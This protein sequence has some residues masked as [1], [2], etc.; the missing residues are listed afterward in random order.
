MEV[1]STISNIRER[2]KNIFVC[3]QDGSC[4]KKEYQ[5]FTD[6]VDQVIVLIQSEEN[7]NLEDIAAIL[8]CSLISV[9]YLVEL[10]QIFAFLERENEKYIV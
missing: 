3:I 1:K 8:Q 5:E 9:K 6:L 2:F 4:S 10:K 7:I